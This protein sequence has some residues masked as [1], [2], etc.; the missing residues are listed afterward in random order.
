MWPFNRFKKGKIVSN[1]LDSRPTISR[2]KKTRKVTNK[3]VPQNARVM[4]THRIEGVRTDPTNT[5]RELRTIVGMMY[6]YRTPETPKNT[7]DETNSNGYRIPDPVEFVILDN[8][9]NQV[10][11]DV[12]LTLGYAEDYGRAFAQGRGFQFIPNSDNSP[13]RPDSIA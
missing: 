13:F 9:D 10:E 11:H 4:A 8:E 7:E 2:P 6:V 12:A 5:E 3:G 1:S